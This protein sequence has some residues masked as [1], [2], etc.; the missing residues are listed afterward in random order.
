[1]H[2][3]VFNQLQKYVTIKLG[4]DAWQKLLAGAGKHG[5]VYLTSSAYPD[6]DLIGLVVTACKMTNRPAAA[7]LE[8]F[9][10]FLVPDLVKVYGRAIKPEWRTIDLFENTESNIHTVV[11]LREPAATPPQLVMNRTGPK[12][13]TLTYS[14]PRKLCAL[15]KG[16]A[17]G[18]AA[19]YHEQLQIAET[20]CMLSGSPTCKI[21]FSVR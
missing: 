3:L 18:I 20:A 6:A 14:S 21:N 8:D 2:G 12:S 15:G 9:G 7:L 16:I 4:S 19:H 1:M 5:S 11:R 10:A 17:R 13:I